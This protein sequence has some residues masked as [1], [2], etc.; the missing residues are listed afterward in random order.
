MIGEALLWFA[1]SILGGVAASIAGFGIGSILTP[2]LANRYS[3][4]DAILAVSIPHA[5]ATALRCWRLRAVIDRSLLK[6][7]GVASAAG[8]LIGAFLLVGFESWAALVLGT[9]LVATGLA[10]LTGWNTRS[11]PGRATSVIL[12][13]LSGL[14]GGMAGNQ[15]GLRAAAMTTYRLTPAQFVATS[16]AVGLMVDAARL[17]VYVAKGSDRI[18]ELAIPIA[19]ATVGVVVGTLYGERLLLSLSPERFR[20][21]ISVLI[22]ALGIWLLLG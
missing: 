15:G 14:F 20:R 4:A 10:G 18:V 21:I 17:P 6:G 16:T 3:V 13:G 5:V 1:T 9:L 8:G 11:Q 12:G 7:F 19:I 2:V 22:I